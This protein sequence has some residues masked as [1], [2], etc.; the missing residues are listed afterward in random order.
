MK[1][2]KKKHLIYIFV[3][4]VVIGIVTVI[5]F[6]FKSVNEQENLNSYN[7]TLNY[8]SEKHILE[9][10]EVVQYV[11]NSENAFNSLFF[12]LYSNAFREG[13]SSSVVSSTS[14]NEAFPNGDSYGEIKINSVMSINEENLSYHITGE[15]L[16]I[17]EVNLP[18]ILYPDETFSLKIDFTVSLPN[19]NHRFGYGE[20]TINLGNFY[21]IACVYEDGVGFFTKPYHSNGDPFYSDVSN[22]EVQLTCSSDLVVASSG[23]VVDKKKTEDK[24]VYV[25]NGEK[26]RDFC[27]VLSEKFEIASASVSGI[28][29]NYFGYKGDTDLNAQVEFAKQCVSTYNDLFGKYP[30]STLNV[31]KSNFVYGGMEYPNLVMISDTLEEQDFQY[32][33]AHEIAHQWWYGVVGNNQYS[34]AWIDEG[35]TEYSTYLFFEKNS[36]YGYNY[37]T[38]INNAL[39]NYKFFVKIYQ[40]INGEVDTSMDKDLDEFNTE[41]EYVQLTYTKGVLLF[42]GIRKSV[43]DKKFLKALK[44]LYEDFAFKNLNRAELI[45]SFCSST[46]SNLENY[47]N[48]WLDGDI[49]IA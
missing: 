35:L 21:P 22:Y 14:F 37:E 36:Q 48:S 32:V 28:T 40:Q 30:Y 8:D 47:I 3:A 39:N 23:E 1:K 49:I 9:G 42:D 44:T 46:R 17:L 19:A 18:E 5:P 7:L 34:N 27:L 25:I 31:V 11:N 12:N 26:I 41:P 38:M 10:S 13:A 6:I 24:T 29:I 2:I 43:G 15:D 33:I 16:N 20:N 45:A 4:V